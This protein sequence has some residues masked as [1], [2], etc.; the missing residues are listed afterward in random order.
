[1]DRTLAFIIVTVIAFAAPLLLVIIWRKKTKC[2]FLVFLNVYLH[3]LFHKSE[4][5]C[6][7]CR[8]ILMQNDFL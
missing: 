3:L 1:M 5:F 6:I 8:Y 4:Y 7:C 2:S